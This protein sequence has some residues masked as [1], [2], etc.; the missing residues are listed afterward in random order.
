MYHW[1]VIFWGI[2]LAFSEV[3]RLV[4]EQIPLDKLISKYVKLDRSSRGFIGLCPFHKEKTPSFHVNADEGYYY[5]FG[6]GVSGNAITFLMNVEGMNFVEALE[7]LAE[8]F[9][10]PE[11]LSDVEQADT[12]VS[13]ERDD[14]FA[15]NKIAAKYFHRNLK[16]NEDVRNYLRE[17]GVSEELEKKFAL[18]DSGDGSKFIEYMNGKG[19]GTNLLMRAGLVRL[20]KNRNVRSFFYNRLL[21]PIVNKK[22]VIGFGGRILQGEGP[23]Y[24]NSPDTPVFN[25]KEH[26]FGIDFVRSG[27]KA[28]P[29]VVLCEGYFDVIAMHKAGFSTAVAALGTAVTK[30][31][32]RSL[33]KFR[34]PVVIFL[35]GDEAGRRAAKRIVELEM[36]DDIDLRVAFIPDEGEDPDSI[37]MK[38]GG[39]EKVRRL[40]ETA[41]ALFQELIDEKLK[42]YNSQENL[43]EKIKI[44][45]EIRELV[46]NIH[47]DKFRTYSR[48]IWKNSDKAISIFKGTRVTQKNRKNENLRKE[49][50]GD[51]GQLKELLYLSCIYPQF[52]PGLQEIE[53][54]YYSETLGATLDEILN[55]YDEGEQTSELTEKVDGEGLF[56][57]KYLKKGLSF[58]ERTFSRMH[59]S[60]KIRLN[61]RKINM[62]KPDRSVEAA[63]KIKALIEENVMLKP[64]VK[65]NEIENNTENED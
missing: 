57:S 38:E 34:K 1:P 61:T 53:D 4:S 60:Q 52:I 37:I 13:R 27:L 63:Q 16:K 56:E 31:H 32:L 9:H 17:R 30:M 47:S 43:E 25:K 19:V 41:T 48:Y 15:V 26:L 23:K 62:L 51:L 14:I 44:E 2:R 21:V 3:N 58:I 45:K 36:P 39:V 55:K 46:K 11:L 33:G 59:A 40:I 8:D 35:D 49:E 29:F 6:C 42:L 22:K 64:L 7:K 20:D 65:N 18:G 24:I 28:F 50:D 12:T 5:C 54:L 10:M